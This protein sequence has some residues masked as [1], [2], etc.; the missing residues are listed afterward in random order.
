MQESCSSPLEISV[1]YLDTKRLKLSNEYQSFFLSYLQKKYEDYRP[2]AVYVTDDNALKFFLHYQGQLFSDTPLF[3]SGINDL[4]L[5]HSLDNKHYTGV[6]ETKEII[7]NIELIRQFS[8]QT[9]EIWIVGDT[10]NTYRSIESDMR[11]KISQYPKYTFH[12]LSSSRID[13]ITAKLPNSP[14]TF[15]VLT[16]IGELSDSKGHNLTLKESIA[17]L[18]QKQ[19]LILC[20]MEDA[21]VQGGVVGGFVTSGANQGMRAAELTIRY[22]VGEPIKNIQSIVKSPNVY[23]FDHKALMESRLILSEYIARDAVILHDKK[24][25]L[26]RYQHIILNTFFIILVLFLLFLLIVFFIALQ[27]NTQL[28]KLEATLEERSAEVSTLKEKLILMEQLYE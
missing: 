7:P 8:P 25:F 4:S 3:F 14:K 6:Y 9:R 26:E 18:K 20:S 15:V 2:D 22:F 19:N 24:T 11:A 21:Y 28:K 10:S 23:M 17:I 16:T 1:E 12:F 13:E 5:A 27:K